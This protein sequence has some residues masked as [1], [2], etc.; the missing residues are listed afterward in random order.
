[1]IILLIGQL[2]KVSKVNEELMTNSKFR[3]RE[4]ERSDICQ[5]PEKDRTFRKAS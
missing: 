4:K 1:M 2:S 5:K 3:I